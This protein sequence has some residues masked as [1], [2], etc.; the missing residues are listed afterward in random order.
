MLDVLPR[1]CRRPKRYQRWIQWTQGAPP[2]FLLFAALKQREKPEEGGH[3]LRLNG[4]TS[5]HEK[6]ASSFRQRAGAPENVDFKTSISGPFHTRLCIPALISP[7]RVYSFFRRPL[8][9]L[10]SCQSAS[11]RPGCSLE[12][13]TTHTRL[14]LSRT[15][16]D[17]YHMINLRPSCIRW[18]LSILRAI[19]SLP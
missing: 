5:S 11:D 12:D 18:Q 15:P 3:Q 1:W 2:W 9:T 19:L 16:H 13:R 17:L 7:L 8:V 4:Y 6:P 14:M 10:R